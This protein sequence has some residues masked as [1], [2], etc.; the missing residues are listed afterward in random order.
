MVF[1]FTML[2]I[3]DVIINDQPGTVLNI[4]VPSD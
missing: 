4:T 2:K 1:V 3:C